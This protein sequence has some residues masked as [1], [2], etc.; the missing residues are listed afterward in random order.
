[1]M[2]I[3]GLFSMHPRSDNLA[4]KKS[5][6]AAC[7]FSKHDSFPVWQLPSINLDAEA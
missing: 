4:M 3:R 2:E 6:E 7:I 1:M 5:S